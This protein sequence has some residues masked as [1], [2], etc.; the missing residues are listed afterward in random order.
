[1][2]FFIFLDEA[3]LSLILSLGDVSKGEE[4]IR[5][6]KQSFELSLVNPQPPDLS[7]LMFNVSL[8]SLF[9]LLGLGLPVK[10]IT[11]CFYFDPFLIYLIIT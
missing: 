7:L 11:I 1:M 8:L 2:A 4:A 3:T 6:K 5:S 9:H 10:F